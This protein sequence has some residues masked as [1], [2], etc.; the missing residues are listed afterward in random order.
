MGPELSLEMWVYMNKEKSELGQTVRVLFECVTGDLLTPLQGTLLEG[1]SAEFI[2]GCGH[3]CEM[4][5]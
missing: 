4:A 1:A 3:A 2:L 5:F